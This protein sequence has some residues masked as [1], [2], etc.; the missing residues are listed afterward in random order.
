MADAFISYSR[1][2]KT[3][4]E[5]LHDALEARGKDAWVDWQRIPISAEWEREVYTAIDAAHALVFVITE[6]SVRSEWCQRELAHATASHKRLIPVVRRHAPDAAVPDALR[7]LNWLFIRE[8]DDFE[9]GCAQLVQAL[10]ADLEHAR[11]HTRLLT[12]ALE[13][14]SQRDPSLLLTGDDLARAEAWLPGATGKDPYPTELQIAYIQASRA[15]ATRA[16][17]RA[18]GM[19]GAALVVIAALAAG[20]W[21]QRGAARASESRVLESG[22]R[23][24]A[25]QLIAE[26]RARLTN[27]PDLAFL[28]AATALEMEPDGPARGAMLSAGAAH[29]HLDRLVDRLDAGIRHL[30]LG[31]EGSLAAITTS[32]TVVVWT[33]DGRRMLWSRSSDESQAAFTRSAFSPDGKWLATAAEYGDITLWDLQTGERRHAIEIDTDEIDQLAFSPDSRQL[34]AARLGRVWL[35]SVADGRILR[36]RTL[37]DRSRVRS[38]FFRGDMLFAQTSPDA[39]RARLWNVFERRHAV[40]TQEYAAKVW[41]DDRTVF[42]AGGRA[43]VVAREHGA[44]VIADRT[45]PEIPLRFTVDQQRV[46]ELALSADLQRVAT[47]GHDGSIIVWRVHETNPFS[48]QLTRDGERLRKPVF[49]GDGRLLAVITGD[50]TVQ[51][52]DVT[53][54]RTLR[55]HALSVDD[56]ADV[57]AL[58]FAM[59]GVLLAL[60]E[61]GDNLRVI[62]V[63]TGQFRGGPLPAEDL[64]SA[65]A[66]ADGRRLA[67]GIRDGTIALWDVAG[68]APLGVPLQAR[69][70][71]AVLAEYGDPAVDQK[72]VTTLAFSADGSRLLSVAGEEAEGDKRID[73]MIWGLA[74]PEPTRETLLHVNESVVS[75]AFHP[76]G[77]LFALALGS[78][79]I[80]LWE[81]AGGQMIGDLMTGDPFATHI[82]FTPD[83][84]RLLVATGARLLLIDVDTL[85]LIRRACTIANRSLSASE[86]TELAGTRPFVEACD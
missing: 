31:P 39:A 45:F 73:V 19:A 77:R 6:D 63:E 40:S 50:R 58:T 8:H 43:L 44:A 34:A 49:S 81:T 17:N 29:P 1:I 15:A 79:V 83:G 84:A 54:R 86:W 37:E 48:D 67:L 59:D 25:A 10:D 9:A 56:D 32:N 23:A 38:L 16:R 3:F 71:E 65:M 21:L 35:A 46:S 2:D 27:A 64:E 74:G 20:F 57:H 30:A 75:A 80:R 24:V 62:E 7:R 41:D 76:K 68:G 4:V 28:L 72:K 26:S 85:A 51:V 60:V 14:Q 36:E 61:Q 47:G 11:T 52:W 42:D 66:S 69:E 82:A 12:R 22:T 5:Q 78:G 53:A 55:E 13:W 70:S 18:L 33:K